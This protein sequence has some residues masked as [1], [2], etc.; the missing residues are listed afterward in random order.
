[1]TETDAT[2]V[3]VPVGAVFTP[4]TEEQ[5]YVWVIDESTGTVS[6]RAVVTGA[7]ERAGIQILEGLKPGD[8]VAIAGVHTLREGQQVSIML[9]D[10]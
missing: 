3:Q 7:L 1:V 10:H 6:K 9:K 8:W 2:G 5:D 4:E